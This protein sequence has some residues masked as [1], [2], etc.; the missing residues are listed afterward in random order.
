[1]FARPLGVERSQSITG[2]AAGRVALTELLTIGM[3]DWPDGAGDRSMT[4]TAAALPALT[5]QV[6][7]TCLN[8]QE[9]SMFVAHDGR[10]PDVTRLTSGLT[11][12]VSATYRM[13]ALDPLRPFDRTW[14][15]NMVL[16]AFPD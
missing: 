4:D 13:T 10:M 15:T 3:P 9:K 6:L 14:V 16:P 7:N 11:A 8:N 12:L 2:T 5:T 1:M